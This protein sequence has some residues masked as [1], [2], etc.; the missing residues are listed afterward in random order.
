MNNNPTAAGQTVSPPRETERKGG[1]MQMLT[2]IYPRIYGG[3]CERCG[4]IDPNQPSTNQYR[5]CEHYRG[6]THGVECSYCE[7][8]KD[9]QEVTRIS[10]MYVYD[11]PTKKDAYGR[12]VLG[13]VCDSF[14]C[15]N[16]FNIE[17]G[18]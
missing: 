15:Q 1:V 16:Q 5:L 18:K 12:P 6:L 9:P 14:T 13:A 4:V 2:R 7:A 3:I 11:H 8:T 10:N 17:F